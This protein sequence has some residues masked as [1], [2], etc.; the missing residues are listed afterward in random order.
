MTES[1]LASIYEGKISSIT[2]KDYRYSKIHPDVSIQFSESTPVYLLNSI[3]RTLQSKL[4]SMSF[5]FDPSASTSDIEIDYTN[6]TPTIDKLEHL[7][8]I[9]SMLQIHLSE[10]ELEDFYNKSLQ[11]SK[12][13]KKQLAE[14]KSDSY[15]FVIDVDNKDVRYLLT[16][17]DI[18]V[19][20]NGILNAELT[21]KF[22]PQEYVL[23]HLAKNQKLVVNMYPS[24]GTGSVHSR[25]NIGDAQYDAI[26]KELIVSPK[27][28][29]SAEYMFYKSLKVLIQELNVLQNLGEYGK[30]LEETLKSVASTGK[31][32]RF[33][34]TTEKNE[35][36]GELFSKFCYEFGREK[37]QYGFNSCVYLRPHV[38]ES[39]I[40]FQ[41]GFTRKVSASFVYKFIQDAK[42][43]LQTN[44][45]N[46]IKMFVGL[47]DSYKQ[48]LNY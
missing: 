31:T 26:T 21:K 42:T 27:A 43:A 16:T 35:I 36:I 8:R 11:E 18:R 32:F 45:E 34:Y 12:M 47:N 48:L 5:D 23:K 28:S 14:S 15:E 1:I 9:I 17:N 33:Y 4:Y 40:Q 38:G 25:W 3:I 37:R 44:L 2:T 24:L 41:I 19:Y 20:K 6:T 13:D 10:K 7:V 46:M 29:Y 22:F 39:C 30:T